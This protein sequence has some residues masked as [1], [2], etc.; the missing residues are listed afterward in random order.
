LLLLIEQQI[1]GIAD[2]AY[3]IAL[4]LGNLDQVAE[5]NVIFKAILANHPVCFDWV[6][7]IIT[8]CVF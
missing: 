3:S 6:S 2:L 1:P 4:G 8:I 7:A 5:A